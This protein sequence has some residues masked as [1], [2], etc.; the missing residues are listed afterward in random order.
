MSDKAPNRMMRQVKRITR[1]AQPSMV[2]PVVITISARDIPAP[3]LTELSARLESSV[4]ARRSALGLRRGVTA[5][6]DG[7]ADEAAIWVSIAG[8]PAAVV[9]ADPRNQANSDWATGIARRIDTILQTRYR[10]LLSVDECVEFGETLSQSVRDGRRKLYRGVP[11]YLLDNG[12]PLNRMD[13]IMKRTT[14]EPAPGALANRITT[15][16]TSAAVAEV[17]FDKIAPSELVL[18]VPRSLVREAEDAHVNRMPRARIHVYEDTGVK[19]PDLA[20]REV[21]DGAPVRLQVNSVWFDVGVSASA[22]WA[23]VASGVRSTIGAH[24]GMLVRSSDVAWQRDRLHR[25]V[26]SL[27]DLSRATYSDAVVAACLRA[28]VRSG[29]SVRNLQRILWLLHDTVDAPTSNTVSFPGLADDVAADPRDDPEWLAARVRA[30]I[31]D[32]AWR[33]GRLTRDVY[34]A[35]G[36]KDG[37]SLAKE[38]D[39]RADTER[40]IVNAYRTAGRVNVAVAP[41]VDAVAPLR[42]TLGA[43][44]KPPKVVSIQELPVDAEIKRLR[45]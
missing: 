3:L 27:I 28:L 32:E 24:A 4:E 8:R 43:L 1:T 19:F 41:S 29:Q 11:G 42:F 16:P 21:D 2:P 13:L 45:L 5:M 39:D 17:I 40:R 25:A 30:R 18:E 15:E 31:T 10:L 26:R 6:V 14:T 23:G 36:V 37:E 35:I 22:G 33:T 12:A 7:D 9:D 34:L 38:R 20:L 44:E